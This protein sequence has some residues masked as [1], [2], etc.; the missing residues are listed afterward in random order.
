MNLGKSTKGGRRMRR[1]DLKRQRAEVMKIEPEWSRKL[2]D[3]STVSRRRRHPKSYITLLAK[4]M[5]AGTFELTGET[6]ALDASGNILD[7]RSK[8][9]D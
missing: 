9:G 4:H 5:L 1:P 3:G 7:G 6:M 2:L 8:C